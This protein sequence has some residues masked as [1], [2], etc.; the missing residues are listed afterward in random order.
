MPSIV[1]FVRRQ[2]PVDTRDIGKLA[3]EYSVIDSS[4]HAADI[5]KSGYL[6]A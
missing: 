4:E 3:I 2:C 5:G 6:I 1:I